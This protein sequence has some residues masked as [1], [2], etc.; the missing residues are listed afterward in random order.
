MKE[1][2][3]IFPFMYIS[4]R[5]FMIMIAKHYI[6]FRFRLFWDTLYIRVKKQGNIKSWDQQ[7]YLVITGFCC[8][9]P[10]YNEVPLYTF[11]CERAE[12]SE[13]ASEFYFYFLRLI[14][15][16]YLQYND[17]KFYLIF[18]KWGRGWGC[19]FVQAMPHPERKVWKNII[20]PPHP[21]PPEFTPVPGLNIKKKS[22]FHVF[23]HTHGYK[24][25]ASGLRD[26]VGC[27]WTLLMS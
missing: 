20:L 13:L 27:V 24:F 21:H 23:V 18:E 7:I 25:G 15:S 22:L 12:T 17:V 2:K 1:E 16:I 4:L 11:V 8:I 19:I 10:L 5:K 26:N 3:R 6:E 14:R 9:W